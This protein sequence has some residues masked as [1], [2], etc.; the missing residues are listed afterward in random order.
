MANPRAFTTL[1]AHVKMAEHANVGVA[2]GWS[3]LAAHT[4]LSAMFVD[5]FYEIGN[6]AVLGH[7]RVEC[8]ETR[9]DCFICVEQLEESDLLG[10]LLFELR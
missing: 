3:Q 8:A 5:V 7:M 9:R 10:A 6:L 1:L 4:L 2:K